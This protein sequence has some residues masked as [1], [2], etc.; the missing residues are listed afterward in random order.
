MIGDGE[1]APVDIPLTA[2]MGVTE[3]ALPKEVGAIIRDT[4][5]GHVSFRE[6]LQEFR[7]QKEESGVKEHIQAAIRKADVLE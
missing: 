2:E 1:E 4:D 5:T 3:R 6:K 7:G